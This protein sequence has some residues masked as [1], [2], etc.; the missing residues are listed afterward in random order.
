MFRIR[1]SYAKWLHQHIRRCTVCTHPLPDV[2]HAAL[3]AGMA[4]QL[5]R[6]AGYMHRKLNRCVTKQAICTYGST[7][8]RWQVTCTNG[9]HMYQMTGCMHK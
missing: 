9:T 3:Y 5:Q 1:V 8:V 4:Q 6:V 7:H 2:T